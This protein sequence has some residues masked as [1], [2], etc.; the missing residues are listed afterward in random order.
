MK[1]ACSSTGDTIEAMLD[2]RFGRCAY[3]VI[4]TVE[5]GKIVSTTT[6]PNL[7]ANAMGGAGIQAAQAVVNQ[8]ADVV[9]SGNIGPNALQVLQGSGIEIVTGI[10]GISVKDA[11]ERYLKGELKTTLGTQSALQSPPPRAMGYGRGM[12][13][14]GRGR[15]QGKGGPP[16]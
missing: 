14:Q 7:F 3:F 4:A 1:I 2:P 13:G 16:F 8:G 6:L 15:R 5:N 10:Y 9:I 12:G 11:I